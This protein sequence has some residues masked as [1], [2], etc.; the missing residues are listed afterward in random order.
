MLLEQHKTIL[1]NDFTIYHHGELS[2]NVKVILCNNLWGLGYISRLPKYT[3]TL[4][5]ATVSI[6]HAV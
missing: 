5:E 2:L 4:S 1:R 6:D 3:S